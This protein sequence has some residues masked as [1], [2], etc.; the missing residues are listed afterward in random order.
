VLVVSVTAASASPPLSR[1]KVVV[2]PVSASN[3]AVWAA[4]HRSSTVH[5][6]VS[7]V[8]FSSAAFAADADPTPTSA[9]EVSASLFSCENYLLRSDR[10]LLSQ[11]MPLYEIFVLVRG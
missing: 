7:F 9:E 8:G 3:A 5:K 6:T 10:D 2:M 4:H 11:V 1:T